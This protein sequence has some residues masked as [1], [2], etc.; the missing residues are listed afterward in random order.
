[1]NLLRYYDKRTTSEGMR[2]EFRTALIVKEH[3]KWMVLLV[4]DAGRLKLVRR[5]VT[6][7]RHMADISCNE[8]KAKATLRRLARLRGTPRDVRD[9]VRAVL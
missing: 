9:A 3:R 6:E 8:R 1:M 5:R 7:Q 2:C 4:V